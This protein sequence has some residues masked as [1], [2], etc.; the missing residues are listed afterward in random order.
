MIGNGSS[1]DFSRMD[2]CCARAEAANSLEDFEHGDSRL[3][4]VIADA[5]CNTFISSVFQLINQARSEAQ[6]GML[7]RRSAT[8]ERRLRYQQDHRAL[9]AALKQRDGLQAKALCAAH[10]VHVRCNILGY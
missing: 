1:D 10:L 7:N 8:P 5:A 4:E 9:V 6:W 2:E 3:H